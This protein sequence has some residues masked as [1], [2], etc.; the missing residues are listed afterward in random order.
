MT[1]FDQLP[2]L[3][4]VQGTFHL[5]RRGRPTEKNPEGTTIDMA[6]PWRIVQ[7]NGIPFLVCAAANGGMQYAA[8]LTKFELMKGV[9]ELERQ[10]DQIR[11]ERAGSY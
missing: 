2:V 6:M 5:L 3:R 11:G 4:V 8:K 1:D 9:E 7:E 10:E